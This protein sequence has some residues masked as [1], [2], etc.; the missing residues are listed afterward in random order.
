MSLFST[1]WAAM[2]EIDYLGP[3]PLRRRGAIKLRD[4]MQVQSAFPAPD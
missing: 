3:K 1:I 2:N 4:V